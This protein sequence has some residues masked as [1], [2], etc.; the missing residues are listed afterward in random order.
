MYNARMLLII[1]FAKTIQFFLRLTDR[2]GG[3]AYPGL[4]IER[5]YPHILHYLS[6]Q[7]PQIYLVSGTNGKTTTQKILTHLLTSQGKKVISNPSGANLV[8]GVASALLENSTF[9]GTIKADCA[10][11]EVEEASLPI[12]TQY[13]NPQII[14][15]TNI[16][17]DQLDAYGGISTVVND[18]S[19]AIANTEAVVIINGNDPKLVNISSSSLREQYAIGVKDEVLHHFKFE[20]KPVKSNLMFEAD[21]KEVKQDLTSI[22]QVGS[23]EFMLHIPGIYNVVNALLAMAA[24]KLTTDVE[25]TDMKAPL[26][27]LS[28]AWGRGEH[29]RVEQTDITT[30]LIKNPAGMTITLNSLKQVPNCN[31]LIGINDNIADGRDV[32]W[33]WDVPNEIYE[34][35]SIDT[36]VVSG[37]R[38]EDMQLRLKYSGVTYNKLYSIKNTQAALEKAVE[39]TK[40]EGK[41][42]ILP[43]YTFLL[44]VRSTLQ[45][46]TKLAPIWK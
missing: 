3:T 13:I 17:R 25:L 42:F 30:M 31:L 37:K 16:F 5:R 29:I 19:Q 45:T 40:N 27:Q 6:R 26:E 35:L 10:V 33:L 20:G 18:L 7:V 41:L 21:L 34:G 36:I 12:L 2:S 1:W 23:V 11:F 39:N 44:D 4:L 15:L 8:R 9:M 46:K 32:S 22:F 24:V 14:I 28:P 38:M 43:T